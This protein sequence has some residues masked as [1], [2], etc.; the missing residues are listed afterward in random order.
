[1]SIRRPLSLRRAIDAH[2]R[3]CTYDP[4]AAGTWRQQATLCTVLGCARHLCRPVTK[5]AIPESV[6]DYYQAEGAE[7]AFF[8]LSRPL[9]GTV[10]EHSEPEECP[11][12]GS[13][14]STAEKGPIRGRA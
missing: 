12:E 8:G 3:D 1:M 11:S 4:E 13:H 6:L 5:A 14:D 9:E 10:S 2:C 7:R